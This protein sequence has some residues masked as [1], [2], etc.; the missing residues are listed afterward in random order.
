M[1]IMCGTDHLLIS[2]TKLTFL[3]LNRKHIHLLHS[4][5]QLIL[6]RCCN[7]IHIIIASVIFLIGESTKDLCWQ[8][9]QFQYT[10]LYVLTKQL[11]ISQPNVNGYLQHLQRLRH[12]VFI[13]KHFLNCI[14]RESS[15]FFFYQGNCGTSSLLDHT[16]N[17]W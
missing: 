4:L 17:S 15:T 11:T 12:I 16:K 1:K 6:C 8:S 7:W 2:I 9:T 14:R 13:F 3:N 10:T 5:F